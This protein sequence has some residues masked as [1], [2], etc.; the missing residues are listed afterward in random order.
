MCTL[1]RCV[2]S[3]LILLG[4]CPPS[5]FAQTAPIVPS[6]NAD[7][8]E[9]TI[10]AARAA[11]VQELADVRRALASATPQ[12]DSA[13][14]QYHQAVHESL[15][16]LDRVYTQQLTA[17]QREKRLAQERRAVQDILQSEQGTRPAEPPPY[18]LEV[19]DK[20]G[21][22]DCARQT[23]GTCCTSQDDLATAL[24]GTARTSRS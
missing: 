2:I 21:N 13:A 18:T 8:S 6:A 20:P 12:Q 14:F 10:A 23:L 15:E 3:F 22:S 24:S 7:V 19:L 17:L 9:S 1:L 16:H 11:L 5:A 4:S